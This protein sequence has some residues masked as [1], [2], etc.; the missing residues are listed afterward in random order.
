M[1]DV[2]TPHAESWSN[3]FRRCTLQWLQT[4][5]R[6]KSQF[7]LETPTAPQEEGAVF[8]AQTAARGWTAAVTPVEARVLCGNVRVTVDRDFGGEL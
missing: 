5:S 8:L 3:W 4:E 7:Y 1:S 6:V 2:A